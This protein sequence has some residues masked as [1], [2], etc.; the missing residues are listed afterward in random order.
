M[1]NWVNS[2]QAPFSVCNVVKLLAVGPRSVGIGE[3]KYEQRELLIETYRLSHAPSRSYPLPTSADTCSCP[4]RT[5]WHR[6]FSTCKQQK[7]KKS[8]HV[9]RFKGVS[10]VWVIFERYFPNHPSQ[11][12]D[13]WWG[14]TD[15]MH[16]NVILLRP[17]SRRRSKCQVA[18]TYLPWREGLGPLQLNWYSMWIC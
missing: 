18:R 13:W 11:R 2:I 7:Q 5:V 3:S 6:V 16:E 12:G 17:P 15:A 8:R 10:S 9:R 4:S 14:I 1:L